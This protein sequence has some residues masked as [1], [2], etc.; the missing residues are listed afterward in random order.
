MDEKP[1]RLQKAKNSDIFGTGT[2]METTSGKHTLTPSKVT[3]NGASGNDDGSSA[4]H[5]ISNSKVKLKS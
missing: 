1:F 3:Q 4:A 2:P 5:P